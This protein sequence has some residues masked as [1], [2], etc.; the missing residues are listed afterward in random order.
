MTKQEF[1]K[2]ATVLRTM[3]K[4]L[5]PTR[6]AFEIWYTFFADD[7][8][9][10]VDSAVKSHIAT[11][12]Y[13]PTVAAIRPQMAPVGMNEEQAWD[14]VTTAI[15][16]S[17]WHSEERFAELPDVLKKCVGSPSQLRQWGGMD[18]SELHTVEKSHFLRT[19]RAEAEREKQSAQIPAA[20]RIPVNETARI[21]GETI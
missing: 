5:I 8:Y 21:T 16:D 2:I 4:D 17:L 10:A 13:P 11:S 1:G 14:R 9:M 19:Y 6:E 12:P 18:S 20:M 3:Y 7:D 15:R